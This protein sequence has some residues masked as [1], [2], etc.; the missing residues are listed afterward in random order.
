MTNDSE[1]F[2]CRDSALS[3]LFLLGFGIVFF[4]VGLTLIGRDLC[5]GSCETIGLTLLYAGG[6]ISAVIGIVTESVIVAWPLDVILWVVLGFT[7]ARVIG[8]RGTRPWGPLLTLIA[9]FLL[10]GLV[11]SQIVELAV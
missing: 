11:L 8:N 5:T 10:Y 7:V 3:T 2:G 4:A 9:L 6:P 1:G